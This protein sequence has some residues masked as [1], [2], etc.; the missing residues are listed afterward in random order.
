MGRRKADI[1]GFIEKAVESIGGLLVLLVTLIT[2]GQVLLR[3]VFKVPFEWSEEFTRIL[4][5]WMVLLGAAI[6]IPKGRH[7]SI[8][9]F[10][11]RLFPKYRLYV[12]L[13]MDLLGIFFL[14]VLTVKGYSLARLMAGEYYLTIQISLKYVFASCVVGGSLMIFYMILQVKNTLL[15]IISGD[16]AP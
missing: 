8:E 4:F 16:N 10:R 11:N 2:I 5:I 15:K 12:Q 9:Y 6:G 1:G 3:Y 13:L 14:L 7:M